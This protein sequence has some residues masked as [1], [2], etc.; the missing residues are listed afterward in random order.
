M[1]SP[2]APDGQVGTVIIRPEQLELE[3]EAGPEGGVSAGLGVVLDVTRTGA[4]LWIRVRLDGQRGTVVTVRRPAATPGP[5][6]GE[7]VRVEHRGTSTF[8]V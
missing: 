8:L 2:A 3:R 5:G 1:A 4:D 7:R 6:A